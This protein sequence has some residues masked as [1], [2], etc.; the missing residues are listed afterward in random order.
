MAAKKT[1]KEQLE[2]IVKEGKSKS[3]AWRKEN[4]P[5]HKKDV[6]DK[7]YSF[8][9]GGTKKKSNNYRRGES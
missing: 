5:A 6:F 8:V 9:T 3:L 4:L 2:S 1:K 7:V